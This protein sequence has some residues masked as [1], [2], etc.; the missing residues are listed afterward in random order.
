MRAG[1][2]EALWALLRSSND[3][4]T[5]CLSLRVEFWTLEFHVIFYDSSVPT[6]SFRS[7]S[8]LSDDDVTQTMSLSIALH[9]FQLHG[10]NFIPCC[11]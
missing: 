8:K 6:G 4:M 11:S 2:R 10:F 1:P 5:S 7:P 3:D 9:V